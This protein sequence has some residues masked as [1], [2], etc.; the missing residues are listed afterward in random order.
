MQLTSQQIRL[1]TKLCP[2]HWD[3][4]YVPSKLSSDP[5]YSAVAQSL[6]GNTLPVLDIGCGMGL[7]THWLRAVGHYV[8]MTGCDYDERKIQSANTMAQHL[9]DVSFSV[10]DARRSL[11]AHQGNVVILDIL[12]F[13]TTEEQN[14]LLQEAAKRVATGGKLLI[15]S[16]LSGD[17]WRYQVT[18][19]CDWLAK[20]TLWMKAAPVTYPSA[21]QFKQVLHH[22]GLEVTVAPLWG[23]TPFYNH[24]IQATR[25]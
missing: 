8:P 5:V 13:F 6:H 4:F 23:K 20:L 19:A 10:T 9:S 21:E 1:I 2:R 18:V 3:K 7:L 12:Q 15:R 24:F 17:S 16:G 14:T 11:P 25:N 22:A